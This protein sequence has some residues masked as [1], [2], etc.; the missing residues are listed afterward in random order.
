[1]PDFKNYQNSNRK[2]KPEAFTS[3]SSG[4]EQGAFKR[5]QNDNSDPRENV[6]SQFEKLSFNSIWITQGADL[7]L[8]VFAENAGA[9][10]AKNGLTNSKIRNI[11]AEI[12]RIKM[13]GNFQKNISSFYLLKPKFAYANGREEHYRDGKLTRVNNGLY[14]FKLIFDKAFENIR[15]DFEYLNFCNLIESILAYHKSNGG[16]D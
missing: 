2:N 7:S 1:M 14:L 13:L 8:V 16:K 11:Y 12:I 4:F 15:S 5:G 10:M 3:K 9:Y 6:K